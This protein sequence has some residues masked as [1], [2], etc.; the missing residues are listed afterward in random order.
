MN[1][2]I[3]NSEKLDFIFKHLN[4]KGDLIAKEFGL[5]ASYISKMRNH[6]N[7]TLKDVHL[8]A[9]ENLYGI[10]IK[11]FKDKTICTETQIISI[12]DK[13]KECN[14]T[15]IFYKNKKLLS[16]L[17][18]DWYAYF[19]PS[20]TFATIHSIRTTIFIDGNVIDENKNFGHIHIGKVQSIIIKEAYNSKNL[21]SLTFDNQQVAYGIF[22]F[23]LASKSNHIN[24]KMCNFGFFSKKQLELDIVK[25]I[26]GDIENMQL[27]INGSF[28]NKICDYLE[29]SEYV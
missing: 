8:Y 4:L 2:L 23:T 5:G 6:Y 10:P 25:T 13:Y 7:N 20:N 15:D 26:L 29:M 12:L 21:I 14:N 11:I 3:N 24:Q 18:G 16:E 17:E 1:K 22:S 28:E 9:F 19:Y 27:K